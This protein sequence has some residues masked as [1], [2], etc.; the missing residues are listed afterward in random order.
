MCFIA[1]ISVIVLAIR[2]VYLGF[3][4]VLRSKRCLSLIYGSVQWSNLMF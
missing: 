1:C 4:H 3:K 2:F